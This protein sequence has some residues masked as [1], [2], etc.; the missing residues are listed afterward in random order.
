MQ[1]N[2]F[3]ESIPVDF[4]FEFFFV[5]S[6]F[7][8][9]SFSYYRFAVKFSKDTFDS[10][11]M[12]RSRSDYDDCRFWSSSECITFFF[13]GIFT[14]EYTHDAQIEK[15]KYFPSGIKKY[16]S[17]LSINWHRSLVFLVYFLG[18]QMAIMLKELSLF[19]YLLARSPIPRMSV[20]VVAFIH[21]IFYIRK[22]FIGHQKT[23]TKI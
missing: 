1:R 16:W 11:F 20:S 3:D 13:F 17:W 23:H 4:Q 5:L 18:S 6:F 22:S 14:T 2:G 7:P 19:I 8:G 9:C 15:R 21:S 12:C 10:V